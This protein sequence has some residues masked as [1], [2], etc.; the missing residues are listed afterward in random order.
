MH[1]DPR[2]HDHRREAHGG[3]LE[4]GRRSER[5]LPRPSVHLIAM[6]GQLPGLAPRLPARQR[7]PSPLPEISVQEHAVRHHVQ[8]CDVGDVEAKP[9]PVGDDLPVGHQERTGQG[10]RKH[11]ARHDATDVS[12]RGAVRLVQH[13]R[14]GE[15]K[16]AYDLRPIFG[17]F[18]GDI[19]DT[20]ELIGE[21]GEKNTT[22]QPAKM[23][24]DPRNQD[25]AVKI[26]T[27]I[28]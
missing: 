13:H 9:P 25:I 3:T 27:T 2:R 24:D 5:C 23:T 17:M 20:G 10:E 6:R 12:I 8:E 15:R 19:A 21:A 26:R 18:A 11:A 22:A 4:H 16:Y 1:E 28:T 14:E 7:Q